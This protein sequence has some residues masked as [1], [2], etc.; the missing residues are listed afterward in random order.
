MQQAACRFFL[1]TPDVLLMGLCAE[2]AWLAALVAP[3]SIL[4]MLPG[5]VW[6]PGLHLQAV[7][8]CHCIQLGNISLHREQGS[9]ACGFRVLG[10]SMQLLTLH[11]CPMSQHAAHFP[12]SPLPLPD[13]TDLLASQLCTVT[14][15]ACEQAAEKQRKKERAQERKAES[16][17]DRE[18]AAAAAKAAAQAEVSAAATQAAEQASRYCPD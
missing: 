16:A 2:T 10:S 3:C 14:A 5:L 11:G 9:H 6:G 17:A 13:A 7:W 12:T 18:A 15:L 8:A 4:S 1:C